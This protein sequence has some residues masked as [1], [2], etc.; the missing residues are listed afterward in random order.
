[1]EPLRFE[2][3]SERHFVGVRRT[4]NMQ[5]MGESIKQIWMD[6]GKVNPGAGVKAKFAYGLMPKN[7]PGSGTFDYMA[8]LEV[9]ALGA[10]HAAYDMLTIGAARYAVFRHDGAAA[11]ARSTWDPIFNQWMPASGWDHDVQPFQEVYD[12]SFDPSTGEGG[13]EIWIPVK[14]KA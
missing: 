7:E 12:E 10:D 8:A 4:I 6:L 1:M 13:F 11:D 2:D 14:A 3:V 9:E 5:T